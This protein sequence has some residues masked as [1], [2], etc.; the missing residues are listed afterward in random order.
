M[1][2]GGKRE[3]GHEKGLMFKAVMGLRGVF[4][5]VQGTWMGGS[6]YNKAYAFRASCPSGESCMN[7]LSYI[8]QMSFEI[9]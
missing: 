7:I 8:A 3:D 9:W 2:S 4:D 5:L 1:T 6:I